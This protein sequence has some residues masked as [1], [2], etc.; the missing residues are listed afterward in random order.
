MTN[1]TLLIKQDETY[2]KKVSQLKTE[3]RR[4]KALVAS[5]TA[6]LKEISKLNHDDSTLLLLIAKGI[7]DTELVEHK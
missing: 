1:G 6:A 3:N 4:L 7:A 5:R 2:G